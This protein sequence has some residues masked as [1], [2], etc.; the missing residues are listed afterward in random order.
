MKDVWKAEKEKGDTEPAGKT[1]TAPQA[2]GAKGNK[3]GLSEFR[4]AEESLPPPP[5]PPVLGAGS[6]VPGGGFQGWDTALVPLDLLVLGLLGLRAHLRG[7]RRCQPQKGDGAV[8]ALSFL[9]PASLPPVPG[10]AES[11]REQLAGQRRERSREQKAG[12]EGPAWG[13]SA[14]VTYRRVWA[15]RQSPQ[16]QSRGAAGKGRGSS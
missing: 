2:G 3:L 16:L 7:R 5:P 11:A 15:P 1:A 6:Q 4:S 13:T 14:G 9:P 10:Y 8:G 12:A